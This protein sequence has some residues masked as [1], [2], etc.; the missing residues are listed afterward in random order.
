MKIRRHASQFPQ[1][2][3]EEAR[4]HPGGWVYEIVGE[5]G[6][7][8]AIPPSA[9]KGAWQVDQSGHLTGEYVEN[10]SF[11]APPRST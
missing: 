6:A 8:D 3:V 7:D 4:A 5:F 11:V 1:A 2:L 10:P 9:I